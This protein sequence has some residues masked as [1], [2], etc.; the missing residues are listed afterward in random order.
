MIFSPERI[1][2]RATRES[3]EGSLQRCVPRPASVPLH[4]RPIAAPEAA[5]VVEREL[6][7]GIGCRR[8]LRCGRF[9]AYA[10]PAGTAPATL[11][12]LGRLRELCFRAA[13]EGTGRERDL[14]L[15]D[16]RYEQ[17]VLWDGRH[18]RI[19]GGYRI[20]HVE[21]LRAGHG[22]AGLYTHSLFEFEDRFANSVSPGLELGRSFVSPEYQRQGTSLFALWKAIGARILEGRDIRWLFGPVSISADYA[23]ESRALIGAWLQLHAVDA[24]RAA[25]LR[26]R[27]PF[28]PARD[29]GVVA[30]AQR[31]GG[32]DALD[33]RIRDLEGGRRGIP[34]LLRHYLG[35]GGRVAGLNLDA[36]FAGV[37]DALLCVDLL[38]LPAASARRYLGTD[39]LTAL[40]AGLHD[41]G[42]GVGDEPLASARD[43]QA[44]PADCLAQAS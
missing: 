29:P 25:T 11:R 22:V 27:Q 16:A 18:Q 39:G 4:R 5:S 12:E 30:C 9:V 10:V 17:I 44:L 15:F 3:I 14:D 38:A 7:L 32:I 26:S 36:Q 43:P 37:L 34:V 31:L 13:G 20:G 6:A 23:P 2:A 41:G 21:Q 24:D 8:L 1:H 40:S 28:T 42:V 19:A 33:A 35:L